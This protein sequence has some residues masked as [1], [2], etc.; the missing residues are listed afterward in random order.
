MKPIATDR[1]IRIPVY[2]TPLADRTRDWVS[3]SDPSSW[4]V[5]SVRPSGLIATPRAIPAPSTTGNSLRSG[6]DHRRT[7]EP[8]TAAASTFPSDDT[9]IPWT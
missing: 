3:F 9:A 2:T 5:A 6:S 4:T 8:L 1:E 7:P